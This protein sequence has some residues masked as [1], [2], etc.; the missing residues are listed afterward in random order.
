METGTSRLPFPKRLLVPAVSGREAAAPRAV[1]TPPINKEKPAEGNS[2]PSPWREVVLRKMCALFRPEAVAY[3]YLDWSAT[4]RNL[5]DA[6]IAATQRP[7][8]ALRQVLLCM[9]CDLLKGFRRYCIVL[10]HRNDPALLFD[11]QHFL[12]TKNPL[13]V[14]FLSKV[15]RSQAFSIFLT[16]RVT[17]RGLRDVFSEAAALMQLFFLPP[18]LSLAADNKP[19]QRAPEAATTPTPTTG[20]LLGAFVAPSEDDDGNES[21][22]DSR[23]KEPVKRSASTQPQSQLQSQLQPQPQQQPPVPGSPSRNR[24]DDSSSGQTLSQQLAPLA[25]PFDLLESVVIAE[26]V[27]SSRKVDG[28]ALRTAFSPWSRSHTL[29][30]RSLADVFA[31]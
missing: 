30:L 12:L 18:V 9:W 3:D 13:H 7:D 22:A 11:T 16:E 2:L 23:E 19:K 10:P 4:V 31:K 6:D 24:R 15:V 5:E 27:G 20:S 28:E 25:G 26:H 8:I 1:A 29:S 17:S 21:T 14:S